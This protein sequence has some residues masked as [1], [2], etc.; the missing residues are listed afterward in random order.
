MSPNQPPIS[1][2]QGQGLV[3]ASKKSVSEPVLDLKGFETLLDLLAPLA[4]DYDDDEEGEEMME[5][6]E[7]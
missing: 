1:A 5:E 3:R 4:G 7:G 6:E 2:G